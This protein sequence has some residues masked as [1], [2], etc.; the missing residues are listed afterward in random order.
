MA[1]HAN[2]EV[3]SC[4]TC[5]LQFKYSTLLKL[6]MKIHANDGEWTCAEC[7]YHTNSEENLK[8]H[9]GLIKHDSHQLNHAKQNYSS[10][11]YSCNFCDKNFKQMKTRW[12]TEERHTRP[13][14][15]VETSQTVISRISA[16]SILNLSTAIHFC[17]MN[18]VKN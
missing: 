8:T 4:N 9:S 12:F 1:T 11:N 18:V 14:S 15:L 10:T 5:E 6:H 2:D 16:C 17:V 13:S 3:Y 7:S